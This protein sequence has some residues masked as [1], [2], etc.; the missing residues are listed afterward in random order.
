MNR[1]IHI[2]DQYHTIPYHTT[3]YHTIPYNTIPNRD[4]EKY[5]Y[6]IDYSRGEV[7]LS[8]DEE[9]EQPQEV[10]YGMVWYGMVWHLRLYDQDGEDVWAIND[11]NDAPLAEDVSKRHGL[12]NIHTYILTYIH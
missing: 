2:I 1:Y 4:M 3:P 11:D 5:K 6:D 10:W 9:D 7:L 12:R 8:S